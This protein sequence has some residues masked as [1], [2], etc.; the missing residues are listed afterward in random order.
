MQKAAWLSCRPRK[1]IREFLPVSERH[2]LPTRGYRGSNVEQVRLLV[3]KV[4]LG[5]SAVSTPAVEIYAYLCA[6]D[7]L[8]KENV[9]RSQYLTT[10]T[11]PGHNREGY[12]FLRNSC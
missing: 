2:P 9:G 12:T 5:R 4:A 10:I 7:R 6:T 11:P 1:H 3:A 8:N